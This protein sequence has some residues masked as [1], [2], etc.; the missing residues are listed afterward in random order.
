MEMIRNT[1]KLFGPQTWSDW[2]ADSSTLFSAH[3]SSMSRDLI[4]QETSEPG[5]GFLNRQINFTA[6]FFETVAVSSTS[7]N[8]VVFAN[9]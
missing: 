2:T 4:A 3:S 8:T 5:K 7:A 1:K 6:N 9:C